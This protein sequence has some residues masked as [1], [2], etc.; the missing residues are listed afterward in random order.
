[1]RFPRN[2]QIFRGQPDLGAYIGVFFLL[3]IFVLLNSAIVFTPGVPIHLPDA[4]E[5]PG[6][7]GDTLVVAVDA[8][9]TFYFDNQVTPEPLLKQRLFEEVSASR[10]PLTL[11]VQMDRGCTWETLL[12][13]ALLARRAGIKDVVP[14]TR[15]A[16]PGIKGVVASP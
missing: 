16:S 11:L 7:A 6:V 13:L 3:L 14:A 5:L 10:H 4:D 2:K 8:S 12:R 1:M 15:P 9:G